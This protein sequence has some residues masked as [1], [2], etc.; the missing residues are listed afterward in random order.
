MIGGHDIQFPNRAGAAA[1]LC[2][3][4]VAQ[5]S[6]DAVFEDA[7]T[8]ERLRE[9]TPAVDADRREL[10]IYFDEPSA[11]RWEAEGFVP[12]LENTMVHVLAEEG[13][14]TVVLDDPDSPVAVRLL[15]AIGSALCD[16]ALR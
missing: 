2:A 9:L 14:A 15:G 10:F 5:V 4:A 3:R 1:D 13:V 12:E 16:D 8:G 6:P 7:V 11:D